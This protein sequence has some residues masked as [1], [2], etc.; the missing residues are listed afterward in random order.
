MVVAAEASGDHLGAGLIRA[1]RARLGADARFVGVGG[2]RMAEE[3]IESP[4]DIRS[5]SVLGLFEGVIAWPRVVERAAR[6][7]EVAR[8]EKPEIAVLIDSWGFTL[9][10]AHRLRGLRPAPLIIKYV[11]PQVWA[12]RPG[13]ARTL[14]RAVDRL[15]SI[16]AFD[17][18]LFEREG[19]AVTFVGNPALARDFSGADP[20]AL[21]ARIGARPGDPIVLVLPGSRLAEIDRLLPRFEAAVAR[22][23]AGRPGLH[24]LVAGA[25]TVAGEVAARVAGW[26]MRA[27]AILGEPARLEAMR[28]ATVA[29]ACSGTVTTELALAGCPMVVAYRLGTIT[30]AVARHLIRTPFITLINVAAGRLVVPEF[31]QDAATGEALAG[32]LARRLDDR[33]LREGQIAAQNAALDIMR[34]GIDDPVGAAA[35]AVIAALRRSREAV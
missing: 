2:A 35:D 9:R 14:A 18:P 26:P 29:L 20:A 22:L 17:A 28:T 6:T 8:R 1:L 4:F 27:H 31:I 24:V 25:E 34:G 5:L 30:H 7:V 10:V 23:K 15:L 13:R 21:R 32:E 16:H 33:A 11:A 3:G 19:L 12:S